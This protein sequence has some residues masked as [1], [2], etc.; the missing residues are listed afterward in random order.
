MATPNITPTEEVPAN[1]IAD[2]IARIADAM[3]ALNASRLSRRAIVTLVHDHSGVAR[4]DIELVINNLVALKET[5]L[6][7]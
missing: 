4:R 3:Q 1:L 2:A 7:R 6:K 5:W